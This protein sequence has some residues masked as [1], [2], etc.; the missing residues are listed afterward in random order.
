MTVTATITG[1]DELAK[2]LSSL[3][4]QV[5]SG[6][7]TTDE[8]AFVIATVWDLGY[9][10]RSIN[11]GPKTLWS[12]NVGGD[13]KVL[14]ITAPTGFI[15]IQRNQYLGVLKDEFAKANFAHKPFD[16]WGHLAETMMRNAAQRCAAIIAGAAP[17]DTGKLRD[18]IVAAEPGDEALKTS[19][20]FMA[21]GYGPY[22][23]FVLNVSSILGS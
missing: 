3:P 19:A 8:L 11:P 15:R 9:V 16:V 20:G 10:T 17:I 2:Q 1:I 12:V 6:V 13:P 21:A 18:S 23:S 14:T 5:R 4:S 22:T 7:K